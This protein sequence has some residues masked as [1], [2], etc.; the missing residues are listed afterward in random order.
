MKRFIFV[1]TTLV[2]LAAIVFAGNFFYFLQSPVGETT[3]SFQIEKKT[4]VNEIIQTL[5]EKNIISNVFFFKTYLVLK[6]ARGRVR[7]GDYDFSPSLTPPQVLDLLMK[8]D[9]KTYKITIPEGWNIRQ[10][11]AH[12]SQMSLVSESRFLEKCQDP[13]FI[14]SL[15]VN[16]PTLEG[17]LFPDTYLVYRPKNEEEIIRKFVD[18]FHEVYRQQIE[19]SVAQSGLTKE[20]LVILA[21]LVEKETAQPSEKPIIASVFFNRL[22]HN[23]QLATDPAV[24]YGV[25]NFSGNL[26]RADLERPGPYNTYLNKGLTPTPIANAGL[27]TLKAVLNPAQTDYFYFVSQGNGFHYF[28]KTEAEHIEAVRKFQLHR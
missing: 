11:A 20:Q 10:I 26:T 2:L 3:Q 14:Q 28:S 25:P 6:N 22:K 7:A 13:V 9:F 4:P 17:Y 8:G 16:S 27:E 21:S 24:I 23:I 18:H 12:L 1:I 5:H 15:Q 19:A